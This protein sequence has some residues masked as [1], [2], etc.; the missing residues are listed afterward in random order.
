[1]DLDVGLNRGSVAHGDGFR[2]VDGA[3]EF[4]LDPD[5]PVE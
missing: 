1:V 5:R 2:A 3:P 4:A